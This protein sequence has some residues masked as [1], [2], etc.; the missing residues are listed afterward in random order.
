MAVYVD[1]KDI[2]WWDKIDDLVVAWIE[3][4]IKMRFLNELK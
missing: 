3:E 2:E 1:S 4:F